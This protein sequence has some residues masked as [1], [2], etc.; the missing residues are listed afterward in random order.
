[1]HDASQAVQGQATLDRLS[2]QTKQLTPLLEEAFHVHSTLSIGGFSALLARAGISVTKGELD[3]LQKLYGDSKGRVVLGL[4]RATLSQRED[5][6]RPHA[7]ILYTYSLSRALSLHI[8]S[9]HILSLALSL[10]H[11]P[12]L[13]LSRALFLAISPSRSIS[14]ALSSFFSFALLCFVLLLEMQWWMLR[15]L[16]YCVY[17]FGTG[18]GGAGGCCNPQCRIRQG[19]ADFVRSTISRCRR[20]RL[21]RLCRIGQ[22]HVTRHRRRQQ[23]AEQRNRC[24]EGLSYHRAGQI[25]STV[26]HRHARMH[27]Q[28]E[29]NGKYA[30]QY[31][32]YYSN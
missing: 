20:T 18:A 32:I 2:L 28:E 27:A 1:M 26:D 31:I 9:L 16:T 4:F 29:S 30:T 3:V 5:V 13:S 25:Q 11:S 23:M 14:C 8:L 7:I 6:G 10:S 19:K 21:R 15:V 17:W 24:F 12:T 22:S